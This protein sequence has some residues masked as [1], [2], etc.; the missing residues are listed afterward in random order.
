MAIQVSGVNVIDN[1]RNLS[2][3]IITATSLDVPPLAIT[4]SPTDGSSDV[5]LTSNI[6]I[7]FNVTVEK[8]SGNITLKDGDK[9]V[10]DDFPVVYENS[11]YIKQKII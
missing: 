3:G 6:V 8:G 7:T 2:A 1:E 5:S 10:G 11:K 4:F 9:L